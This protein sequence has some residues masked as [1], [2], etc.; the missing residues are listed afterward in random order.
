MSNSS[1][2]KWARSSPVR[3]AEKTRRKRTPAD[4]SKASVLCVFLRLGGERAPSRCI[5]IP[6]MDRRTWMQLITI[7]AAVREGQAQQRNG[8]QQ[9]PMRID[10]SQVVGALQLLGLEF[11][12]SEIDMMM[13]GV[14]SA[15]ASYESLRKAEVPL[16]T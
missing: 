1:T 7:L 2:G 16:S 11:Q 13:R 5:I 15:I 8:F 3:V 4:I 9:Q 6:C 12:E 14:N 10:K